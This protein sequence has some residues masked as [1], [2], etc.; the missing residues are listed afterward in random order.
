MRI[1]IIE[2]KIQSRSGEYEGRKWSAL[3][4]QLYVYIHGKPFP[5]EHELRMV[6]D[7]EPFKVGDYEINLEHFF[8]FN[9]LGK[10][11]I[12]FQAALK[13]T[14]PSRKASS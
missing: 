6:K 10:P 7:Q 5:I 9:R 12:D 11:E 4:Q 1:T 14:Q 13:S 8:K 2:A 3:I